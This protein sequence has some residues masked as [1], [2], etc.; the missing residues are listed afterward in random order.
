MPHTGSYKKVSAKTK[1]KKGHKLTPAKAKKIMKEG[2][3]GGKK[4][5][6]KQMGFFGARSA[7]LKRKK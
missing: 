5:T 3:I 2:M 7:G 6:K 4:L 1:V